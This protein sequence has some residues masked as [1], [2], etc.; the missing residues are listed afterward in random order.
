MGQF[1]HAEHTMLMIALRRMVG[2]VGHSFI[3]LW[4]LILTILLIANSYHILSQQSSRREVVLFEKGNERL[5]AP[6]NVIASDGTSTESNRNSTDSSSSRLSNMAQQHPTVPTIDEFSTLNYNKPIKSVLL[7][8]K[9]WNN[10]NSLTTRPPER[11]HNYNIS[12]Q[13]DPSKDKDD[14]RPRNLRL[15]IMGDSISRYQYISLVYFLKTGRWITDDT[16]LASE[17]RTNATNRSNTTAGGTPLY[18]KTPGIVAR[19]QFYQKTNTMLQ[20][21]ES[22]DCRAYSE[23]RYFVDAE[24][25]NYVTYITKFGKN[26]T[27]GRW[28]PN[29]IYHTK[30]HSKILHTKKPPKWKYDWWNETIAY[31]ISKLR[32]K[33]NFL[34]FN[35]G[36][37]PHDLEERRVRDAIVQVT[38]AHDILPIY[39]TTTYPNNETI[40]LGHFPLTS[41]DDLLCGS[42][43]PYCLDLSWTANLYGTEH[44]YDYYHLKPYWNRYMNLQMLTY[45]QKITMNHEEEA[46][47]RIF[48][49]TDDP[50][51]IEKR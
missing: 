50:T 23:N 38:T 15:V 14:P 27:S 31:H 47:P 6:Y 40:T 2:V 35:A 25:G 22:C 41:H 3:K 28:S 32:P 11:T 51:K 42:E 10:S 43:M 5:V 34:I 24:R 29:E 26:A 16:T 13:Y 49:A 19:E 36:L 45:L 12:F 46:A 44:Y 17:N 33:P 37:H 8:D 30:D 20:P 4:L 21:N 48:P 1:A 39:K 7:Q 18:C 9:N